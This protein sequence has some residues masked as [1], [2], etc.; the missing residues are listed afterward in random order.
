MLGNFVDNLFVSI[1]LIAVAVVVVL[2]KGQKYEKKNSIKSILVN[3]GAF[4]A[5]ALV[6]DSILYGFY[7]P[8]WGG[9][10]FFA[11]LVFQFLA[12]LIYRN[13]REAE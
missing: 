8:G 10:A 1:L 9:D 4:F 3:A 13:N 2:F 7:N 5:V 6:I 11:V 12:L